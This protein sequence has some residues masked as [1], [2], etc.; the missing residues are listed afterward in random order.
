MIHPFCV[1]L[2][3]KPGGDAVF[4]DRRWWICF[5]QERAR[6]AGLHV[7]PY[8][9]RLTGWGA[10]DASSSTLVTVKTRRI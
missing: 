2:V 9:C 6:N 4:S 10:R 5:V 1:L 3:E 7:A 8:E